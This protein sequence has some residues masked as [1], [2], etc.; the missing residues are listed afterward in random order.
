MD[1]RSA[2]QHHSGKEKA[3]CNAGRCGRTP[4]KPV[5]APRARCVAGFQAG[6]FAASRGPAGRRR[7]AQQREDSRCMSVQH[8]A[9]YDDMPGQCLFEALSPAGQSSRRGKKQ[10]R[11]AAVAET[12][13]GPGRGG[14][15]AELESGD[16]LCDSYRLDGSSAAGGE[17]DVVVAADALAAVY[18][19]SP[20]AVRAFVRRVT[21]ATV[22][23]SIGWDFIRA[24]NRIEVRKGVKVFKK[25][26]LKYIDLHNAVF[27][28]RTVVG[29]HSSVVG[30]QLER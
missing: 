10:K 3:E 28:G 14:P 12:T 17:D 20:E 13:S 6:S 11:R 2:I 26:P 15:L 18:A 8:E 30:S 19:K 25:A 24:S 7:G 21:P 22:V 16:G 9:I 27:R 29:D 23:H 4:I 5:G 1:W